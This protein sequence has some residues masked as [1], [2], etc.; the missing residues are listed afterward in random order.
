MEKASNSTGLA[1]QATIELR[2]FILKQKFQPGDLLPG[3]IEFSQ[4]LGVSRTMIREALS[5]FRMMGIIE[6]RRRRGMILQSPDFLKGLEFALDGS[7][8]KNETLREMFEFR[9]MLE[10]GLA[11]FLFVIKKDRLI[12]KL[13]RIIIKEDG[14]T[15]ESMRIKAD[16]EF[17]TAL[18]EATGNQ[19]LIRFQKMLYPLFVK[20]ASVRAK[21]MPKPL[22]THNGLL[23][24]LKTGAPDTFREA[25][26]QHLE[27]HFQIQSSNP[28]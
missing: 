18:Y 3:E 5:R 19:T 20:Y 21:N 12:K 4:Q 16:A 11:D 22:V 6:S 28:E 7:W 2:D 17:H 8:L 10:I 23:E 1:D 9:L 27:P 13:E 14:L 15:K 26:R 24:V 25:M